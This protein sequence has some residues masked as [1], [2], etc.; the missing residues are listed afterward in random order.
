[1]KTSRK[2]IYG[3]RKSGEI[4]TTK[5]V[6]SKWEILGITFLLNFISR[7]TSEVSFIFC[8]LMLKKGR[9]VI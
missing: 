3:R 5:A 4:F 1:M 2:Q 7:L 9:R 6:Y 8:T